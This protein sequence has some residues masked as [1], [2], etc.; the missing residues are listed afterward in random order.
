MLGAS[1]LLFERGRRNSSNASRTVDASP[2]RSRTPRDRPTSVPQGTV[3]QHCRSS[4]QASVRGRTERPTPASTRSWAGE[5]SSGLALP[6]ATRSNGAAELQH[7]PSRCVH[8]WN[9]ANPF[10][11]TVVTWKQRGFRQRTRI[12]DRREFPPAHILHA[13]D[14]VRLC[15]HE[16]AFRSER[17]GHRVSKR[18]PVLMGPISSVLRP[19]PSS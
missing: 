15:Q 7:P 13:N 14:C 16:D 6:N 5:Q 10:S 17:G 11:R 9:C 8:G 19:T 3:S 12:P 1:P 4:T 18:R 2:S